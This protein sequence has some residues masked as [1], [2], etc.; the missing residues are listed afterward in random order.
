MPASM[1]RHHQSLPS[2][3]STAFCKTTELKRL[4]NSDPRGCRED[5][6]GPCLNGYLYSAVTQVGYVIPV[7]EGCEVFEI[8]SRRKTGVKGVG[9]S[10]FLELS[11]KK[12]S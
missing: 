3:S 12:M 7:T 5:K 6:N 11:A 10:P 9:H 8:I 4:E 1:S 2:L